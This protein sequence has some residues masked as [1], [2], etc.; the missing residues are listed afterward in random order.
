MIVLV[1]QRS[2]TAELSNRRRPQIVNAL[3]D[4][5]DV[6]RHLVG[7]IHG[8]QISPNRFINRL[9]IVAGH[10]LAGFRSN[11]V[12]DPVAHLR[13][14]DGCDR[15]LGHLGNNLLDLFQLGACIPHRRLAQRLIHQH[16]SVVDALVDV[17][18]AQFV[19]V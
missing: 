16:A 18:I 12:P 7:V 10:Q 19:I 11:A 13:A 8:K 2:Q 3:D 5:L 14:A 9:L 15:A 1:G 17:V 4:F 6:G